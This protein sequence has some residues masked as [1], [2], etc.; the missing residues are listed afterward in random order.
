MR[1]LSSSVLSSRLT[2]YWPRVGEEG[3]EDASKLSRCTAQTGGRVKEKEIKHR[4]LLLSKQ[5]VLANAALRCVRNMGKLTST[6]IA[7]TKGPLAQH[8]IRS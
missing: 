4:V 8:S 2:H 3:E 5:C 1:P 7:W 6:G